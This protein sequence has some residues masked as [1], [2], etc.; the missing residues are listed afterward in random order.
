MAISYAATHKGY[1]NLWE[2]AR[3]RPEKAATVRRVAQRIAG[4]R[5]RYEPVASVTGVPWYV[6]AIIHQLE[7]GGNFNTHLHNGDPLTARTRRVPAGRPRSGSPPF[8]W[9]ASAVDALRYMGLH[10][11]QTWE[12]PRV[13]YELERYNGQGYFYKGINSPY[14]WSMTN[15]YTR[16]KYVAD[17]RY[18]AT[19]V[20]GQVGAAAILKE[21]IAMSEI[22]TEAETEDHMAELKSEIEPFAH[23]A[24]TVVTMIGGTHASFAVKALAEAFEE[25]DADVEKV[26]AKIAGL[27]FSGILDALA[28]AEDLL[29]RAIP[30]EPPARAP[31]DPGAPPEPAP[32]PPVSEKPE[33][34]AID[35]LFPFSDKLTG[36]KTVLGAVIFVALQVAPVFGV[37]ISGEIVTVGEWLAGLLAGTGLIAKIERYANAFRKALEGARA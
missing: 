6:I 13:L 12:L 35:K 2:K 16:G 28:K 29:T 14:L 5:S 20:S 11:V 7:S 8:T 25:P 34:G 9:T 23:I 30:A 15:L 1:R 33:P 3:I 32:K 31:V 21:L 18:S 17:G 37:P 22:E 10:K 19:A 27:P 4:L 24:P 36:W 26:R